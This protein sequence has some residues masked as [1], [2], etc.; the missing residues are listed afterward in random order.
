MQEVEY[1]GSEKEDLEDCDNAQGDLFL[2]PITQDKKLQK[3]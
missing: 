2:K 1:I 3:S